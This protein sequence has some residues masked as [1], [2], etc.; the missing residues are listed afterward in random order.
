MN[1]IKVLYGNQTKRISEAVTSY[2]QLYSLV[3][4]MFSLGSE[5]GFEVKMCYVDKDEEKI[6]IASNE[7]FEQIKNYHEEGKVMK[8]E[9]LLNVDDMLNNVNISESFT[10]VDK[11]DIAGDALNEKTKEVKVPEIE[12]Y[13]ENSSLGTSIISKEVHNVSNLNIDN[14]QNLENNQNIENVENN[15]STLEKGI[16]NE[17]PQESKSTETLK[18]ETH[19]SGD[20][21]MNINQQEMSTQMEQKILVESA[22]ECDKVCTNEKSIQVEEKKE[23]CDQL[24]EIN[25]NSLLQESIVKS[26]SENLNVNQSE[27]NA[28]SNLNDPEIIVSKIEEILSSKM[29][30][31]EENFKKTMEMQQQ[32]MYSSRVSSQS[33]LVNEN[34]KQDSNFKIDS[35]KSINFIN[36][37]DSKNINYNFNCINDYS[38][39]FNILSE[40]NQNLHNENEINIPSQYNKNESN[41]DITQF[42]QDDYCSLC[43]YQILKNKFICIL[44]DD[45]KLCTRCEASHTQHPLI[46]INIDCQ[47]YSSKEEIFQYITELSHKQEKRKP[48]LQHIKKMF[49]PSAPSVSLYPTNEPT[50]FAM[51][52][53][54]IKEYTIQLHNSFNK[55]IDE[56]IAIIPINNKNFGMRATII[57]KINVDEVKKVPLLFEAPLEVGEYQFEI[58]ATMKNKKLNYEP[59]KMIVTVTHQKDV[60][61]VN[62][63]LLLSSYDEIMKLPKEDQMKIYLTWRDVF[64]KDID[65]FV[66]IIRKH[67]YSIEEATDDLLTESDAKD[68]KGE[69]YYEPHLHVNI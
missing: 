55:A 57:K 15:Q 21:T 50:V 59:L 31:I 25:K 29:K 14:K 41:I 13:I 61:E 7:D 65:D 11:R 28:Q 16:Q 20:N 6:E 22:S 26:I 30:E 56:E 44:C 36:N 48:M 38:E 12:N 27:Q 66:R 45:F 42:F 40:N 47:S 3:T 53:G 64:S 68:N 4:Q 39:D 52:S 60:D 63:N 51:A 32:S 24:A 17:M 10:M 1:G 54:S 67:K 46:K 58:H 33:K 43:K 5:E 69:C 9:V 62:C 19:E 23:V 8:I 18:I 49:E 34:V 37:N 35:Q 2:D